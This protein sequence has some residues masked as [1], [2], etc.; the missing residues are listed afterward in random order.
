MGPLLLVLYIPNL[1]KWS[2]VAQHIYRLTLHQYADDCQIYDD[3]SPSDVLSGVERSERCL[4]D[5][6]QEA[7]LSL[8]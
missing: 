1:A 4:V 2:V 5:V 8:G 6:E 3:M 7:K